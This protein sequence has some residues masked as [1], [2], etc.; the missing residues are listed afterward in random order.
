MKESPPV[1][2]F[3]THYLGNFVLGLPWVL[4]VLR[5]SPD[6]LLVI[7]SRFA[8]LADAVLPE[9]SN[10]LLYPRA[11]LSSSAPF[12]SRLKKYWKF[13]IHLR[14]YRRGTL[15]DL[16]GERFT[17]VLARLSACR[18]RIGPQGKRAERFY[19]DIVDLDYYR[20]RF[21]AFGQLLAIAFG[22]SLAAESH[23]PYRFASLD[24]GSINSALQQLMS[25]DNTAKGARK[26]LAI[27]PGASVSYKLWP[28]NNFV[29]LVEQLEKLGYQVI[30]VGA[31]ESDREIIYAVMAKLPDSRATN[32]CD[33][34]DFL[35][36]AALLNSVDC[37]IGSDSGPMHLAA[38][39]GTQV[40]ALF[41]PSVEAIWSPLGDNA[42]VL[43]G[44][45]A[46]GATCDAWHCEFDYHCL[47]S[48]LPE[49]VVAA[50]RRNADA[51]DTLAD[52][53]A[54]NMADT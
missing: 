10:I 45:K 21:N 32:L 26:L 1:L 22:D 41:G 27:H 40:L 8:S 28:R 2:L 12:F 35:E 36:L 5:R 50:V 47:S 48:L 11:E 49:Q 20:H 14:K 44:S 53:V 18:R 38:S 43:R 30:W 7:D 16:E 42:H 39:T 52:N 23:L 54:D 33:Q 15:L 4:A 3:P 31:G 51:V 13:I 29:I 34:L 25:S 17:G 19:T 37:F 24:R 6:A 9:N 46:C